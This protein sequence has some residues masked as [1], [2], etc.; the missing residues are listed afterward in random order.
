MSLAR[1]LVEAE[2]VALEIDSRVSEYESVTAGR[3]S[4][5]TAQEIRA[6]RV[7]RSWLYA[8]SKPTRAS[9]TTAPPRSSR[10]APL[11]DFPVSDQALGSAPARITRA[12]HDG[13]HESRSSSSAELPPGTACYIWSMDREQYRSAEVQLLQAFAMMESGI[14]LKRETLRQKH[15]NAT[16]AE[17]DQLLR[18]WLAREE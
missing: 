12:R 8:H 16:E 5:R 3:V 1:Y 6:A 11:P 13:G 17:I 10:P 9:C 7:R 2:E 15:P 14:R 4:A 18:R